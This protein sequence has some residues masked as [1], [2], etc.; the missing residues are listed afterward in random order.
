M[1]LQIVGIVN[2]QIQNEQIRINQEVSHFDHHYVF[3]LT[4]CIVEC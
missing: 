4:H 3:R 2:A 1:L